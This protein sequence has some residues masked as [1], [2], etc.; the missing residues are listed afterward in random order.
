MNR[1]RG[2]DVGPL[3]IGKDYKLEGHVSCFLK[4]WRLVRGRCGG[5][6]ITAINLGLK[7]SAALYKK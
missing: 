7:G 6:I 5:V 3:E 4:R 2:L 1:I